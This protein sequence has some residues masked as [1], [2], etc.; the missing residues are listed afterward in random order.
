MCSAVSHDFSSIKSILT[1]FLATFVASKILNAISVL[2]F[3]GLK[4][5]EIQLQLLLPSFNAA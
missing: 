5:T 4:R 1:L 3:S 2:V